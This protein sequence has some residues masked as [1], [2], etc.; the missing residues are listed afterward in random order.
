VAP[1]ITVEPKYGVPLSDLE[2]RA[3][4]YESAADRGRY[5]G[6]FRASIQMFQRDSDA[7]LILELLQQPSV[8]SLRLI[9]AG[10]WA[11]AGAIG[12]AYTAAEGLALGVGGVVASTL[13]NGPR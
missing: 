9:A 7:E 5:K 2:G 1:I 10:A 12:G 8:A 6:F 13:V 3:I 4:F 11:V